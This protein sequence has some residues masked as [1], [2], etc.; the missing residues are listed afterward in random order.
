MASIFLS[1]AREDL[2]KAERIA[3]TLCAAGHAVWWD[4]HLHAGASFTAEID[5]QLR[6]A[7]HVVVLW[8]ARSITSA[9]VQ[10]EAAVGRDSGRL[11]PVLIAQVEPPLGFRQYQAVDLSG[12]SGRGKPHTLDELIRALGACPQGRP[13]AA[14]VLESVKSERPIGRTVILVVLAVLALAGS[15][16]TWLRLRIH[17]GLELAITAAPTADP[18]ASRQ[19]ASQV[20]L[21]LTRFRSTYLE[22]LNILEGENS[23]KNAYY[24]AQLGVER[25]GGKLHAGIRLVVKGRA[26]VSWVDTIEGRVDQQ[27]DLRQ[28]AAASLSNVLGCAIE[29][30]GSAPKLSNPTYRLFLDGCSKLSGGNPTDLVPTFTEITKSAPRFAPAFAMLALA[31]QSS[32]LDAPINQKGTIAGAVRTALTRA[33]QLDPTLEEV[34]AADSLFHPHDKDQWNHA[35]PILARGLSLHPNS[36]FLFSLNAERLRS[37]GRMGEAVVN[38]RRA[39]GFDPLSPQ[40]RANLINSL[41]YSNRLAEARDELAKAEA[42]WPNSEILQETRYRIDLR[43]GDPRAALERL[44]KSGGGDATPIPFDQSWENFLLAR[45]DPSP[46]RI[47]TA[48]ESFRGRYKRDPGDV[49]GYIQALGTFARPGE[50]FLVTSNPITVDSLEASSDILFRPHMRNLL[51]DPRF[52]R[53]AHDLGLLGYWRKS[54]VWPDFCNDPKLHYDCKK[55]ALRYP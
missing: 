20:A 41:V 30:E 25:D 8:S 26:G 43:Y 17:G 54:G 21:D 31:Q 35:F 52:I 42:I 27:V 45:I 6:K 13:R 4:R 11:I 46:A 16:G 9:W 28:Q 53:L 36:P 29:A 12:W 14:P 15:I 44:K 55:E 22:P 3:E 1:Y 40:V 19:F 5:E 10:D 37:V 48:L 50:A 24:R 18:V 33:K 7:D 39:M 34:I 23:G 38:A 47:E 51:S 2:N 49:Q 32:L